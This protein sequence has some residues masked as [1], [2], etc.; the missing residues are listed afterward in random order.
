MNASHAADRTSTGMVSNPAHGQLKD[1]ESKSSASKSDILLSPETQRSVLA[2]GG[3]ESISSLL[4]PAQ[5]L[6]HS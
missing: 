3:I 5:Y 4:Y 1:T 2:A 6:M